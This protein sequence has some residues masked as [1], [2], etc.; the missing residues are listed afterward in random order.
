MIVTPPWEQICHNEPT[1]PGVFKMIVKPPSEHGV[2]S[3]P[4]GQNGRHFAD[5]IFECISVMKSFVFWLKFHRNL[6]LRVQFPIRH[7]AIIWTNADPIH[8]RIYMALGEMS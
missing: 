7:Q 8:W 5:Y 4:P 1:I 2:N 3:S 6:F